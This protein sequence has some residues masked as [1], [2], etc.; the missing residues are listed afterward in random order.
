MSIK[1]RAFVLGILTEDGKLVEQVSGPQSN[2]QKRRRG[3]EMAQFNKAVR[4]RVEA[5]GDGRR[6]W[7]V[8]VIAAEPDKGDPDEEDALQAV[9]HIAQVLGGAVYHRMYR[10][11]PEGDRLDRIAICR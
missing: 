8:L 4:L 3:S 9:E 2:P 5:W 11:T 1:E 6:D 10:N 7:L